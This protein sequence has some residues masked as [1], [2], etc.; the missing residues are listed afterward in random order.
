MKHPVK[1]EKYQIKSTRPALGTIFLQGSFLKK[2]LI[3]PLL[4]ARVDHIK[5]RTSKWYHMLFPSQKTQQ[6]HVPF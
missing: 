5:F 6:Q 1:A 2:L 4:R 3:C